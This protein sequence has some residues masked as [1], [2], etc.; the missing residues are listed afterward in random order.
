MVFACTYNRL[1]LVLVYHFFKEA[2]P[3]G[4]FHWRRR[5]SLRSGITALLIDEFTSLDP[6]TS[7]FLRRRFYRIVP[8]LVFMVLVCTPFLLL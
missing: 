4:A 7:L 3:G 6:L 2:L 5:G 8:P 1:V